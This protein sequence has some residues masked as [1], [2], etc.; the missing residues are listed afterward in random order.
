MLP[1][2][3]YQRYSKNTESTGTVL[4]RWEAGKILLRNFFHFPTQEKKTE[5]FDA[6][7][8]WIAIY[9]NPVITYVK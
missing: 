6:F 2:E 7:L 3:N 1:L 8:D 9:G 4:I 5:K